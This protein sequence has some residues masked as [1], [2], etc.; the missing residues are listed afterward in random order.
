LTPE[1]SPIF[2]WSPI[3]K[4][5]DART[6]I[7]GYIRGMAKMKRADRIR[8]AITITLDPGVLKM[9]RSIGDARV[10]P[11]T[12]SRIVDDALSEWTVKH[13]PKGKGAK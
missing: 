8:K 10:P 13:G 3:I 7:V 11:W 6:R 4:Y 1:V 2:A 5:D 9:A 12:I